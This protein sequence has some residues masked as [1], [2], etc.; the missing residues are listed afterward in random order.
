MTEAVP[1]TI[2]SAVRKER[3]GLALRALM[4]KSRASPRNMGLPAGSLFEKFFSRGAR[5][6]V[7]TQLRLK[8]PLQQFAR[9]LKVAALLNVSVGA[10][11]DHLGAGG[12]NLFRFTETLIA[13]REAAMPG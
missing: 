12:G 3:T 10:G 6:I 4:L 2:P 11:V 13:L 7:R 8:I 1:M 5:R 9:D